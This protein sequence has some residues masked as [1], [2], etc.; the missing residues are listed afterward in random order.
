MF[1]LNNK[2]F[3]GKWSS[4][5]LRN[6]VLLVTATV[7][8]FAMMYDTLASSNSSWATLLNWF[9]GAMLGI[10]WLVIYYGDH[11]DLLPYGMVLVLCS[12]VLLHLS[13]NLLADRY[14]YIPL[15][16]VTAAW[17]F[18]IFFIE[19]PMD[20]DRRQWRTGNNPNKE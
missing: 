12:P 19:E 2:L 8:V 3:F 4:L 20:M 7:L 10:V 14:R 18:Y 5:S 16:A 13:G 15:G 6:Q 11:H 9:L 17:F 1:D